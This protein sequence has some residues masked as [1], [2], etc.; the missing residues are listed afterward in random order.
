MNRIITYMFVLF[1]AC[2]VEINSQSLGV[3]YGISGVQN[4]GVPES[5]LNLSVMF[6]F[7][8]KCSGYISFSNWGGV[9]NNLTLFKSTPQYPNT[10]SYFGNISLGFSFLYKYYTTEELEYCVGVGL[11]QFEKIHK[12]FGTESNSFEPVISITPLFIKYDLSDVFSIFTNGTISLSTEGFN[13]NWGS[14]VVGIFVN[15]ISMFK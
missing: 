13:P 3:G 1:F 8:E 4:Y 7:N 10:N 2:I 11:S 6:E 12:Y 14:L 9:D 15:P 5:T